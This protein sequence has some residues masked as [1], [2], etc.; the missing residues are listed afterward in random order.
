MN[1]NLTSGAAHAGV[2]G[3]AD[4]AGQ[5]HVHEGGVQVEFTG[6]AVATG[7]LGDGRR[8]ATGSTQRRP[9][10]GGGQGRGGKAGSGG[11]PWGTRAGCVGAAE[12]EW[13]I[14]GGPV[15]GCRIRALYTG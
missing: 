6:A 11:G 3:S 1:V 7:V 12:C 10:V 4:A 15:E 14:L 13:C 5:G 8:G 9:E 2:S